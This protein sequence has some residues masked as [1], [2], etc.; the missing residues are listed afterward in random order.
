MP[1]SPEEANENGTSGAPPQTLDRWPELP[2]HHLLANAPQ[3]RE[4]RA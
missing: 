2:Q 1:V 3:I 4:I